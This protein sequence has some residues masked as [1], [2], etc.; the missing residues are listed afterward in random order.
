MKT[1]N[2]IK[3]GSINNKLRRGMCLNCYR[4]ETGLSGG[5]YLTKG[6]EKDLEKAKQRVLIIKEQIKS[7]KKILEITKRK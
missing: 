4:E 7:Q 1:K 5:S 6:L 2:C 3:C